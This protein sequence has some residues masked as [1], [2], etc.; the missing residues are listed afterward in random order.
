MTP[1]R[2]RTE[3]L[4]AAKNIAARKPFLL[5]WVLKNMSFAL[6]VERLSETATLLAFLHPAP[7][8][9]LHILLVPKRPIPSL[10]ELDPRAD[11]EFLADVYAT[12][13]KLVRQFNLEAGG[14]RLIVN[15][16]KYQDFPY[17]HFHLVAYQAPAS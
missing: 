4:R 17:L 14:Y 7:A 3:G 6:P 11:S 9:P 10:S 12:T 16:G 1:S 15:G 5:A 8:Y 2:L 13:Q